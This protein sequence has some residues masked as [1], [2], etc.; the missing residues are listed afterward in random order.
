VYYSGVREVDMRDT[1][2]ELMTAANTAAVEGLKAA[3]TVVEMAA[4]VWGATG[5]RSLYEV[6]DAANVGG[7]SEVAS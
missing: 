6:L 4:T 2:S 3:H 1:V 5:D 7:G